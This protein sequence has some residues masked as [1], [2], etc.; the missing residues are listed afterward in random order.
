[1]LQVENLSLANNDEKQSSNEAATTNKNISGAGD[2][3]G[4]FEYPP[5]HVMTAE[6]RARVRNPKRNAPERDTKPAGNVSKMHLKPPPAYTAA[7][8]G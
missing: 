7:A 6:E 4:V 2:M 3:E 8:A 5:S 1:M